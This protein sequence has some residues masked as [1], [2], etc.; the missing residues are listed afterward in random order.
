MM[1]LTHPCEYPDGES[2]CRGACSPHSR[3]ARSVS[4]T[5]KDS[6]RKAAR[7]TVAAGGKRP[8]PFGTDMKACCLFVT[9]LAS[10]L[11]PRSR[12]AICIAHRG[13]SAMH[14]ENTLESIA[15]AWQAGAQTVEI[16]VRMLADHTMVLF[17]DA[18]IAETKILSLSYSELQALTPDYHVPTL[19]EAL[20]AAPADKVLLLDLKDKSQQFLTQL[21][22]HI[23]P[24]SKIPCSVM[25][26]ARSTDVLKYVRQ[27]AGDRV[28]LFLVTSLRR[29]KLSGRPPDPEKLA[30]RLVDIGVHGVTAKGRRFVTERYISVFQRKG[31]KYFVWTINDPPRMKHYESLGVDGII[32][33]NPAA[34]GALFKKE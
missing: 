2:R 20:F 30:S 23:G 28:P 29:H 9:L 12:A 8:E 15:A 19:N 22:D 10:L 26:Q 4:E 3:R 31:L 24:D 7:G 5:R 14:R 25:I 33:D 27:N 1:E 16:D 18:E 34:F 21:I 17:H 11:V 13:F 32:T 6:R